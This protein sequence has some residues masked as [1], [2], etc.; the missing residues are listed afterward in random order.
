MVD[1]ATLLIYLTAV[2]G[3]VLIPGPAVLLT[4]TRA[5]GSG[6]HVGIATGLGI[7]VGDIVHTTCSA[8]PLSSRRQPSCSTS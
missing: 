6:R 7:A 5:V 4:V 2:T 8:C 1:H 3:F